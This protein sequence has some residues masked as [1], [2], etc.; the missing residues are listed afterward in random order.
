MSNLENSQFIFEAKIVNFDFIFEKI[1]YFFKSIIDFFINPELW[2]I[3]GIISMILSILFL[4][5]IIFS[6]VR[7]REIQLENK[8]SMNEEI[9]IALKKEREREK[10]KGENLRWHYILNLTESLNES[11]WRVAVLEADSMLEDSLRKKE[12]TGETVSEL[13]EKISESGYIH[14]QDAWKAHSVR[15]KIAH[16][17]SDFSL[18]QVEARRVIKMFQNFF[19]EIGAI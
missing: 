2:H 12:I 5:I 13:L 3:L 10:A 1:Y 14:Y 17:G 8:H 19:E 15:N 7:I 16:Q 9:E 6:L 11:D 18:S 4:I